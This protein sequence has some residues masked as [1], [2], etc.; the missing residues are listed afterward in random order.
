MSRVAI[1][2]ASV[3][4][5]FI[6]LLEIL[7]R[8]SII[9]KLTMQPPHRMIMDLWRILASGSLNAAIAKT[10]GNAATAFVPVS[11]THLTLPTILRV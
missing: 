5:G 4:V 9:D 3:V 11:Y 7:C 6:A 8:V 2:Q 1:Y 10:L